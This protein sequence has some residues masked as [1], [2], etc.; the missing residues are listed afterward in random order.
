MNLI[1][2]KAWAADSD[3]P[4]DKSMYLR[5]RGVFGA[6]ESESIDWCYFFERAPIVYYLCP[7]K[8]SVFNLSHQDTELP[9]WWDRVRLACGSSFAVGFEKKYDTEIGKMLEQEKQEDSQDPGLEIAPGTSPWAVLAS[10]DSFL[11]ENAE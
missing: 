7:M 11:T 2:G 4:P 3:Y 1:K 5:V 10:L 6:G 8:T 9:C